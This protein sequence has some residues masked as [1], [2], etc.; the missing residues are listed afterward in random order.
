MQMD[1]MQ[2]QMSM[3][4]QVK[5]LVASMSTLAQARPAAGPT[6]KTGDRLSGLTIEEKAQQTRQRIQATKVMPSE[7]YDKALGDMV[8]MPYWP[9]RGT[10]RACRTLWRW[11]SS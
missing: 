11:R 6:A 5:Q 3:Q 2:E 4:E 8:D 10:T 1:M 7:I 9:W